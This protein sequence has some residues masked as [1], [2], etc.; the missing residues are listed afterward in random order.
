MDLRIYRT[1]TVLTL[2]TWDDKNKAFIEL[3]PALDG[4]SKG[5]PK[6]GEKRYDYDKTL[7]ISFQP[8]DM[9][10]ASYKLE[11]M[12]KGAPLELQKFG[13][14][15]KVANSDS[16]DKKSLSIK[17][18]GKPEG[19]VY[20]NLSVGADK[21]NVTLSNEEAYAISRWFDIQA[22]KFIL[23]TVPRGTE[24]EHTD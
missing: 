21:I 10:T 14:M 23:K 3:T 11:G 19:G 9:L 20:V 16:K 24:E 4:A 8:V 7:R 2:T 1:T 6:P 18:T 5:Q 12:S 13:D 22:Q 15:S 17:P